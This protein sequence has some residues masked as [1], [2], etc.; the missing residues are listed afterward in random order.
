M[1]HIFLLTVTAVAMLFSFS[2]RAGAQAGD[3]SFQDAVN[4]YQSGVYGKARTIFEGLGD[5][6]SRAY[7]VLCAIKGDDADHER[8]FWEYNNE[9]PES[10][11]GNRIRYEYAASLFAKEDYAGAAQM[12]SQV[13]ETRLDPSDV[14]NYNFRRG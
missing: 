8:V 13:S 4:L 1:K 10:V 11:L 9:Y 3:K 12:L 5:P 14:L 6:M 2:V 7:A